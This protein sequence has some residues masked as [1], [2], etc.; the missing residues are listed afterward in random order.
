MRLLNKLKLNR[1][2]LLACICS[3]L[4]L[5]GVTSAAVFALILRAENSEKITV[6][7]SAGGID[8]DYN[9]TAETATNA[10]DPIT[11]NPEDKSS[12]GCLVLH[13]PEFADVVTELSEELQSQIDKDSRTKVDDETFYF[14][15]YVHDA[16]TWSYS[17]TGWHIVDAGNVRI[18]GRT[19]FQPGD[20]IDPEVLEEYADDGT[21]E[22]EALWGK[23]YFV[24]NKYD[25][26]QYVKDETDPTTGRPKIDYILDANGKIIETG[27][28]IRDY[29]DNYSG[30]RGFLSLESIDRAFEKIRECN[31][32]KST[33][34]STIDKVVNTNP[35][36][37]DAYSYV[38]MLTTDLDYIKH[39]Q[40]S[41]KYFGYDKK[42]DVI[43]STGMMYTSATFKSVGGN[44]YRINYKPTGYGCT[45]LCNL[46]FDNV[47]LC[48]ANIEGIITGQE[49][50]NTFG[51]DF[52][53]NHYN[54]EVNGKKHDPDRF[55]FEVT[56]REGSTGV[57]DGKTMDEMTNVLT[58]LSKTS[59]LYSIDADKHTTIVL[60]GA[61]INYLNLNWDFHDGSDNYGYYLG[62]TR[63]WYVGR[64]AFVQRVAAANTST[65]AN[66]VREN[67]VLF[68][69]VVTGGRIRSLRTA[70]DG[71]NSIC[72]GNR[73]IKV[74][75]DGEANGASTTHDPEI[76]FL[77][78]GGNRGRLFG[79]ITM[80]VDHC[81]KINEVYGGGYENSATVYGNIEMTIANSTVAKNVYGGGELSSLEKISDTYLQYR[82]ESDG[83]IVSDP[84]AINTLHAYSTYA[85]KWS[86]SNYGGDVTIN[87]DNSHIK[88]TVYGTGK[89]ASRT[90]SVTEKINTKQNPEQW[91]QNGNANWYSGSNA[92]VPKHFKETPSGFPKYNESDGRVL[93]SKAYNYVWSANTK[94]TL[95]AYTYN[96]Y[97]YLGLSTVE[98]VTINVTGGTLEKS[99]Y[100]GGDL[101]KVY[102][103]TNITISGGTVKGDVYGG[104]KA[105][106]MSQANK[107]AKVYVIGDG[108]YGYTQPTYTPNEV[109]A[110]GPTS[111]TIPQNPS[112]YYNESGFPTETY[113]WSSDESLLQTNGVDIQGKRLYSAN[114]KEVG[115]VAG[116]TNVT[117][118]GG[119][120]QGS[121][122]GGGNEGTVNGTTNVQVKGGTLTAAVYGGGN[123]GKILGDTVVTMT[124]GTVSSLFGGSKSA[125][126]EG[127]VTLNFNGGTMPRDSKA[128]GGNDAGGNIRGQINVSM[129]NGQILYEDGYLQGGIY[130]G[131][132]SA[133]YAG[134]P[135]VTI[136][137]GIV[138]NVYGGGFEG[139]V[140]GTD[141]TLLSGANVKGNTFGGGHYSDVNGDSILKIQGGYT[142]NAY[143]ANRQ[144]GDVS[145]DVTVI[146]SGGT[147]DWL[148]GGGSDTLHDG[149]P[150]VIVEQTATVKRVCGGGYRG[151]VEGTDILITGGTINHIFAG[152]DGSAAHVNGDVKLVVRGTESKKIPIKT[153]LYGGGNAGN[154]YGNV[155]VDVSYATFEGS[156]YDGNDP[157]LS[158]VYG[159]GNKG[160]VTGNVSLRIGEGTTVT[161]VVYGGGRTKEVQGNVTVEIAG[162]T[163]KADVYGGGNQGE[164]WGDTN[165]TIAN[166]AEVQ[167]SVY[168]GGSLSHIRKD[169]SVTISDSTV[170]KQVYGGGN[171]GAVEGNTNVNI[172][173]GTTVTETVYGGGNQ[174]R[175]VG[176]I[177]LN[178]SGGIVYRLF[179]GSNS[180]DIGGNVTMNL[181]G[182]V[183]PVAKDANGAVITLEGDGGDAGDIYGGNNQSGSI[184]GRITINATD[185]ECNWMMGGGNVAPYGGTTNIFISDSANIQYLVGGGYNGS[186]G[187]TNVVLN[188]GTIEQNAYA[189][190]LSAGVERDTCIKVNGG[191]I[192][193]H[194]FGGSRTSGHVDGKTAV[195]VYKGN[196]TGNVY[197]GGEKATV[198]TTYVEICDSNSSS[199]VNI[200]GS[201]FG[202]GQGATA[203]VFESTEVVVDM[204]YDFTATESLV[205][206]DNQTSGAITT[207]ITQGNGTYGKIAGNVYG[208]GDLGRV[209]SGI[210]DLALNRA[211]I[212]QKAST[213]V[214]I[215]NGHIGNSVFG[216]GNGTPSGDV[217]Y[218]VYMGSVFG[219]T[220]TNIFGGYIEGNVYGGGTQSRLF[221]DDNA[222]LT[223]HVLIDEKGNGSQNSIAIKG[224]VFGGGDRGSEGTTNASVATTVGNAK[225]EIIGNESGSK[226]YFMNGGVYGDGNLCMVSGHREIV[227]TN[228]KTANSQSGTLKTFYSL[229]RADKVTVDGSQV[230]L[231]GA[232][233]LVESGDENLYSVNRVN[234][235][236][237][238]DGS[239]IK[240]NSTVKY[241]SEITSDVQT[242]R[243]FVSLGNNGT[244]NYTA[245]GYN[246]DPAVNALTSDEIN[247]YRNS[248]DKKNT[249]CV[250]NGLSLEV[251]NLDGSY[252]PV[253]GLFTLSLLY[254]IP[255]EGGGFVYADIAESTGDFICMTK[256]SVGSA[257]YMDIVDSVGGTNT[258]G[259]YAYYYWYIDGTLMT[260]QM[261]LEAYIGVA[262]TAFSAH[263]YIPHHPDKTLK[264]VLQRVTEQGGGV[265]SAALE[266]G[267][268]T[269]V[270]SS[271]LSGNQIAIELKHGNTSLGFLTNNNGTW[272]IK[273]GNSTMTGTTGS[274]IADNLLMEAKLG[275]DDNLISVVLH[276]S[277][278]INTEIRGVEFEIAIDLYDGNNRY[279]DGTNAIELN[280]IAAI[281]RLYAS[282]SKYAGDSRLYNGVPTDS[283]VQITK[284]SSY[285][286]EYQ[287]N[288][289][290]SNFSTVGGGTFKWQ[291]TTKGYK[292]YHNSSTGEY[293]TC[294][295]DD[296]LIHGSAGFD[297]GDMNS[298]TEISEKYLPKGTKI[299]L[300]DMTDE[301]APTY[302]YYICA[303]ET[304]EIDLCNFIKMGTNTKLSDAKPEFMK[305]YEA[306]MDKSG[307]VSERLVLVCDFANA[308]WGSNDNFSGELHLQHL[309][310]NVDVMD[311]IRQGDNNYLRSTPKSSKYVMNF[312]ANG[313]ASGEAAFS[314]TA[315]DGGKIPNFGSAA[316]SVQWQEATDYI[317]TKLSEGQYAVRVE[318]LDGSG[319]AKKFPEGMY[320]RCG[321]VIMQPDGDNKFVAIEVGEHAV[322][323][324]DAMSAE[325]RVF[326]P[327][328]DLRKYMLGADTVTFRLSLYNSADDAYVKLGSLNLSKEIT[329]AIE[330]TAT[331]TLKAECAGNTINRILN[332]GAVLSPTI[333]AISLDDTTSQVN[334]QLVKKSNGAYEQV[335]WDRVF[336]TNAQVIT[337][338]TYTYD[339]TTKGTAETG[340][341][342][343]IFTYG[344]RIEYLS[345]MVK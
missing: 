74:Y 234:K 47:K 72:T 277:S 4:L 240:L 116:N 144:S 231:L 204:K 41:S 218:D 121:V 321:D 326:N 192:G 70:G 58:D 180:A 195:L 267:T 161:P 130:G 224:S 271:A 210:I 276:K 62:K 301:S 171:E 186:V 197:G 335:S 299:T 256:K 34:L 278:A 103:D 123:K 39:D 162:A 166:G 129:T 1:R 154:V 260:Y 283:T 96:T 274:N 92:W 104:G 114:L 14:G 230:V 225:V 314:A 119:H 102:G 298:F 132:R 200:A 317:N 269:L 332:K 69:I 98:N 67:F 35:C 31:G 179:G 128:F 289:L 55:Y 110:S 233:D 170:R 141:V 109:T 265:L 11:K 122:Y 140:G 17:F 160:F 318:L 93:V 223:A 178:M 217:T 46:R 84:V 268:Y 243:Y 18:P 308:E 191:T 100:G 244:N 77:Y 297:Q 175:I 3:L 264:Y 313:M 65:H 138:Y 89:G 23:C 43:E 176:N 330:D 101:A 40:A 112:P 282:Q 281:L 294:D 336:A 57:S 173:P 304:K 21:L 324:G 7:Y 142:C 190:G 247:A 54:A 136:R 107:E 33:D 49:V 238:K 227:M 153:H 174:G 228:F 252:G 5:V 284:G 211:T 91:D 285:S 251:K 296:R 124:G 127:N 38:L 177:E 239:T 181:S 145:G 273:K 143:G 255:G 63:H 280:V 147:T 164:V 242:E 187:A 226:I 221:G 219:T 263:T 25:N 291:L 334:V 115:M 64:E 133:D 257:E 216:G 337:Q 20:T 32:Y 322:K 259:R 42:T 16:H 156:L 307:Q 50:T 202:G 333:T 68:N 188:G 108:K 214:T 155:D 286:V 290:P 340:S 208:G 206:V 295:N 118:S 60:N 135:K 201:V 146:A 13:G 159:G 45:T 194:L 338:G 15:G 37:Y 10:F 220:K 236:D 27:S 320:F 302:Y 117:I 51:L 88:G 137:G 311:Y 306:N 105:A 303:A 126:I 172:L 26:M 279:Q 229:Q 168:G 76:M 249:I 139:A 80:L 85:S 345:F 241:L 205:T 83:A 275:Y 24:G 61:T 78:G 44:C 182:G 167:K 250:A 199:V 158:R 87:L 331:Y 327:H 213:K 212:T 183:T 19:V 293:G 94:D 328:Y 157:E 254:A 292:Y 315:G 272:G 262:D 113:T 189:G 185:C 258:D 193:G 120:V 222:G 75:G 232:I 310:N 106:D 22:L 300:I 131:G 59:A 150:K 9:G 2:H 52:N 36:S 339:W 30:N 165:L 12:S 8:K 151:T 125:D 184:A 198:D 82:E 329:F 312:S 270:Q 253:H 28:G 81:T 309:Y 203:T 237:M 53:E 95:I 261:N 48:K 152:G 29:S 266:N 344:N 319:N 86:D 73:D 6:T 149:I 97:A 209:G 287:T 343:I 323:V 148:Y 99:I 169:T 342:R 305:Q 111:V 66:N 207:A 71:V 341:Y 235:L 248:S 245:H 196:I 90:A 288:Y 215:K 79:D 163:L 325:F 316:M 134:T 246:G 56:A